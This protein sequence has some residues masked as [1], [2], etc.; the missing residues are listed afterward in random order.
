MQAF[1]EAV[2]SDPRLSGRGALS[3][4]KSMSSQHQI[5]IPLRTF[6]RALRTLSADGRPWFD[7]PAGC[8]W[9]AGSAVLE[10]LAA[11]HSTQLNE[12]IRLQWT[13]RFPQFPDRALPTGCRALL[14]LG[15]GPLQGRAVGWARRSPSEWKSVGMLKQPGPGMHRIFLSGV[16]PIETHP[17]ADGRDGTFFHRES[18]SRTIGALG[19]EAYH[20]AVALTVGVVGTGRIGSHLAERLAQF[21]IRH[22]VLVDMDRA[23]LSNTGESVFSPGDV[24]QLKVEAL[25]KRLVLCWPHV[26][27]DAIPVSS[28]HPEAI[29]ALSQC[30]FLFACPD[31][32]VARLSA[33][34]VAAC[35]NIPLIDLGTRIFRNRRVRR[36]VDV[37]LV[38]SEQ[39]CLLCFG[40]LENEAEAHRLLAEPDAEEEFYRNRDWRQERPGS[41]ASLNLQAVG[42]ALGLFEDFVEGAVTESS[43]RHL[44]FR[45]EGEVTLSMPSPQPTAARPCVCAISGWGE[46]GLPALLPLLEA[47]KLG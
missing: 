26:R 39:R 13:S 34:A 12:V 24:G 43:W 3:S 16:Q 38:L 2:K 23:E 46:A 21:G 29:N 32:A 7:L 45:A 8:H 44:E 27:V 42:M 17:P 31:H 36:Q 25:A 10:V 6:D 5:N 41:L 18:H 33:T 4:L 14:L 15:D 22:L 11:R 40:G 35:F 20:R 1:R 28:T 19:E 37:R 47:R 30:D 9:H